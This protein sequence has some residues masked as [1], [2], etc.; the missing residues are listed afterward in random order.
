M[1]EF[2]SRR[3]NMLIGRAHGPPAFRLTIQPV[4]RAFLA[5]HAGIREARAGHSTH[6]WAKLTDPNHRC[7][8][9]RESWHFSLQNIPWSC[10]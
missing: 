9:L 4:V 1:D 7:C 2:L 6:G 8:L 10:I 5:I 3:W